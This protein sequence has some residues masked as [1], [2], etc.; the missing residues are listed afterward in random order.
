MKLVRLEELR[1]SSVLLAQ[2]PPKFVRG[3]LYTF[4]LLAV[5]LVA[6][7]YI[8]RVPVIV[9]ADGRIRPVGRVRLLDAEV[10][11][12]VVAVHVHEGQVVEEGALLLTL[13]SV[14]LTLEL[15]EID[16]ELGL[17]RP[18][19]IE[20]DLMAV[21]LAQYAPEKKTPLE[22]LKLHHERFIS[23]LGELELA[24]V[25]VLRRKQEL[26]RLEGLTGLVPAADQAAARLALAEAE[27][28]SSLALARHRAD[29]ERDRETISRRTEALEAQR[30]QKKDQLGRMQIRSAVRGLVTF[31]AV[32][33]VGEV[34]KPGQQIYQVAPDGTGFAAEVW[35]PGQQAGFVNPGMEARVDVPTFPEATFGWLKGKVRS[36]SPDVAGPD[37]APASEPVYRVEIALADDHLTARDGRVGT[38]RLGLITRARL[39]VREERLLFRLSGTL[40]E[41]FRWGP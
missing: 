5:V 4:L 32:R 20:L 33:H 1:E 35:V 29:V 34:V 25:G 16:R 21:A 8:V 36:I 31:A 14:P 22:G 37:G 26:E 9:T 12:R 11:G 7:S 18:E 40:R 15:A 28:S 19:K 39:V 38:L 30:G 10:G 24:R 3:T 13:D 23:W 17:L 41:A 27:S 2:E 6:W